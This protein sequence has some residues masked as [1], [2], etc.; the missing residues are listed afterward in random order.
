MHIT[1]S[2]AGNEAVW[3][4]KETLNFMNK[5]ATNIVKSPTLYII[6]ILSF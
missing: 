5:V 2:S 6:L 4:D 3:S 1:S